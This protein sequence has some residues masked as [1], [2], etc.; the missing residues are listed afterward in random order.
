VSSNKL[1]GDD[2]SD[3][4]LMPLRYPAQLSNSAF[5]RALEGFGAIGS[6]MKDH[7]VS[8]PLDHQL[9]SLHSLGGSFPH[10]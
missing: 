2:C 1:E 5:K 4:G 3:Y 7:R 9:A 10:W 6:V 8:H